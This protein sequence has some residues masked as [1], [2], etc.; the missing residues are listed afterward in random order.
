PLEPSGGLVKK[1]L[2]ATSSSTHPHSDGEVS[3]SWFGTPETST[4]SSLLRSYV[5]LR[6]SDQDISMAQPG[7]L[8]TFEIN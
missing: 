7:L 4:I 6:L 1:G 3:S 8:T 2:H 5:Y